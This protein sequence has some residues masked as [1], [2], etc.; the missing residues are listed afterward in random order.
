[1]IKPEEEEQTGT[2]LDSDNHTAVDSGA[3]VSSSTSEVITS[4]SS[5]AKNQMRSKSRTVDVKCL[6]DGKNEESASGSQQLSK[7]TEEDVII[8][9][10]GDISQEQVT[11]PTS[12]GSSNLP[13][14]GVA[15]PNRIFVGGIPGEVRLIG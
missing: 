1:M 10:G 7:S 5:D 8:V 6:E 12:V 4:P 14:F 3:S 13:R 15:V 9:K 11:A 2:M